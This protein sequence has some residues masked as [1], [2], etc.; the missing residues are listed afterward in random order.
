MA[1]LGRGGVGGRPV[2][3]RCQA[4]P[5]ERGREKRHQPREVVNFLEGK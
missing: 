1:Y 2:I 5:E 4:I 3:L